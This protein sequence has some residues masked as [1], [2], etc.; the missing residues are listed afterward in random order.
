M[1]KTDRQ[2][3]ID[4][5]Q[6]FSKYIR[7]YYIF[8]FVIMGIAI[9]AVLLS[10]LVG[11]V[12]DVPLGFLGAFGGIALVFIIV[13]LLIQ[14]YFFKYYGKVAKQTRDGVYTST[15]PALV[16]L[17]F[18]VIGILSTIKDIFKG[19]G[20]PIVSLAIGLLGIYLVYGVYNGLKLIEKNRYL[21][22][23]SDAAATIQ[24]N[25]VP[26]H[27]ETTSEVTSTE[28]TNNSADHGNGSWVK[29]D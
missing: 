28:V 24:Y 29:E 18:S 20:F 4:Q 7:I 1:Y 9:I 3:V 14:I 17:V 2:G 16:N 21:D 6:Q 19:E 22:Y 5:V 15:T 8:G 23:A 13:I 27:P 10:L 11:S 26:E 25:P 12:I